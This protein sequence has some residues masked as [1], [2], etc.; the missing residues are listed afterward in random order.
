MAMS[1]A[2]LTTIIDSELELVERWRHKALERAGYDWE[3]AT[4]LAAR[5]MSTCTAPSSCSN[6]AARSISRSRSFSSSQALA[7]RLVG[8]DAPARHSF[9]TFRLRRQ[10]LLTLSRASRE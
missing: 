10:S 5:T 2:N 6:A 1:A 8:A 3:A 4:V 9:V 7:D